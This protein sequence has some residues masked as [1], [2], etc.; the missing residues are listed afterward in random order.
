MGD[1][2][3][4]TTADGTFNAYVARPDTSTAPAVVV[5]QELFGVNDD[6]RQTC[7]ELAAHGFIAICPDLFWR[8]K[9]GVD[10]DVRSEDD[11]QTGLALYQAFDRDLGVDD[12]AATVVAVHNLEGSSGKVGL[13]GYC[14]GG[15]MTF[16]AAARTQVDAAVAYHGADTEKYLSE[17]PAISA[18]MLMH[19]AGNDE[20]M[21]ELARTAIISTLSS[22]ANAQV[23]TYAGCNHAF[24]RHNGAHYDA[25]A[26][27]L[28]K[29]RTWTF[30]A[31][32][33]RSAS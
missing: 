22:K 15:L 13:L 18:P 12:V 9:P 27:T 24:S 32:M 23:F 31:A 20:F 19:L 4:I 2:I 28:S 1:Q 29:Q 10:L 8:Q 11:W 33:L 16:L 14:L 6:M 21:P 30:L 3:N 26:A 5:L 25:M 7:D 17:A